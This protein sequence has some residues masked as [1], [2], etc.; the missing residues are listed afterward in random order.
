[1]P[2]PRFGLEGTTSPDEQYARDL[3]RAS[4]FKPI[5]QEDLKTAYKQYDQ[6]PGQ[7]KK[8]DTDSYLYKRATTTVIDWWKKQRA[9]EAAA[10]AE[11]ARQQAAQAAAQAA[12]QQRAAA[13][14]AASSRGA[15][16]S[17]GGS[18][19]SG[20]GFMLPD[21]AYNPN[22]RGTAPVL[23][24][25]PKPLTAAQVQQQLQRN[26]L[27]GSKPPASALRNQDTFSAWMAQAI[28]WLKRNQSVAV[29]T[30]TGTKVVTTKPK[31]TNRNPVIR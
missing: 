15:S 31:A 13:A 24:P 21:T 10:K 6:A 14:A 8:R 7:V 2:G 17:G 12:A 16:G 27:T 20:G 9:A 22:A 26:G 23:K 30:P 4:S 5:T 19:S 28:A 18:G 25:I 1:M 29:R 11:A 3:E